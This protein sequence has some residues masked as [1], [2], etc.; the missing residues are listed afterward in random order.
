MQNRL[1][2]ISNMRGGGLN[3]VDANL[4][5]APFDS[6][7]NPNKSVRLESA[8]RQ[9]SAI[10]RKLMGAGGLRP[11]MDSFYQDRDEIRQRQMAQLKK[12]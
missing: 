5:V 12:L 3:G 6:V 4:E 11:E 8:G 7:S 1:R 2:A 10:N 9:G